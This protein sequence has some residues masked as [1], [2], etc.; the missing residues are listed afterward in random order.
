M[1]WTGHWHGFGPWVGSGTEYAGEGPRRPGSTPGDPR[2]QAFLASAVPPTMTGHWLLRRAQAA[3]GRTW[4]EVEAAVAW[5]EKNHADNPP[6]AR[7]DGGRSYVGVET[8]AGYAR[9]ALPRGVDVTWG[10]WT[11]SG[12]MASFSV[13]CCPNRHHPHTPCPLPPP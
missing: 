9:D 13:V 4:T 1:V 7:D 12:S 10:Y 2:T 3:R 5:L 11:A 6:K 8:K